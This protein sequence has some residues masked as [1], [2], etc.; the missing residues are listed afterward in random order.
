[1]WASR[2]VRVPSPN[3][4]PA[5]RP[6]RTSKGQFADCAAG[7]EDLARRSSVRRE[8]DE[9]LPSAPGVGP[10]LSWTLPAELPALGA[11]DRK[12]IAALV[13]VAPRNRGHDTGR[14]KCMIYGER[15]PIHAILCMGALAATR[16]H[17][18]TR[19][20]DQRLLAAGKPKKVALTAC[21]R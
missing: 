5:S 9:L 20:L 1:M 2:S 13:G 10:V 6:R 15:A 7:R 12:A 18:V 11:L 19:A 3:S 16:H 21:A 4:G 8:R 14:G 17:R